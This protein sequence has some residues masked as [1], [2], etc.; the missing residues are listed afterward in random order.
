M[1]SPSST[2]YRPGRQTKWLLAAAGLA[3]ASILLIW[4][5]AVPVGP[6]ACATTMPPTENCVITYRACD[7]AILT[8]IVLLIALATLTIGVLNR[9]NARNIV[10][11]GTVLLVFLLLLVYPVVAY[12]GLPGIAYR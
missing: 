8:G 10:I 5:V 4:L 9:T 6:M 2:A 12:T 3:V 7:G 1:T 11:A